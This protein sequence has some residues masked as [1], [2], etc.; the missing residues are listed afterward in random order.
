MTMISSLL[1]LATLSSSKCSLRELN[2]TVLGL[3]GDGK[4]IVLS[5][6]DEEEVCEE[7]TTGTEDVVASAAV[8][9]A[10]TASADADSAPA[11]AKNDNSND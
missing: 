11:R 7:K 2:R 6:S 1:L 9:P 10:S 4:I 8:N 5:D 3:P